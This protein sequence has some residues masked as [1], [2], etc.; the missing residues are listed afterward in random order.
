MKHLK[1][2]ILLLC[3]SIINYG[4]FEDNDDNTISANQINDFVWKGMNLFYLYKDNIPNLAND[5]FFSDDEYA[6]YLNSFS[7]PE[8]L[9]ES[10]IYQRE[11]V[12]RYS[13]IV[14]D[15]IAL[16]RFFDGCSVINGMEFSLFNTP[17]TSN[18]VF[19]IVRMVL[20]GSDADSKGVKRGDIFYKVDGD[21][22]YYNSE[23]DNNFNLFGVHFCGLLFQCSIF[24]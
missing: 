19:G 6:D 14:N 3:L 8:D 13:W 22:L 9:F 4:C 16:E 5:R 7:K 21:Q 15:Y 20:T 17:N 2:P 23:S 24:N 12:D 11:N 10:L 18:N 1:V